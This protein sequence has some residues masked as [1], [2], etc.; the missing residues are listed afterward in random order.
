VV[1]IYSI[2]TPLGAISAEV[3]YEANWLSV[4]SYM[5]LIMAVV[6]GSFLHIS[7]TILFEVGGKAHTFKLL[8]LL[9]VL[10]GAAMAIVTVA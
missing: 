6:V 8:R 3:F 1:A 9:A 5:D 10:V 7:T 4:S 2:I